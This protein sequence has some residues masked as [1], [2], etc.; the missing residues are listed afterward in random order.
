MINTSWSPEHEGGER[1]SRSW[2]QRD[3]RARLVMHDHDVVAFHPNPKFRGRDVHT[4]ILN[5]VGFWA[6]GQAPDS[7][8]DAI[9]T[10]HK[11]KPTWRC[12]V[13][14]HIDTAAIGT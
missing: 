14:D 6:K 8:M 3:R 13:E 10:N 5:K 9:G 1:G 11:I 7:G 12:P 4:E 2:V